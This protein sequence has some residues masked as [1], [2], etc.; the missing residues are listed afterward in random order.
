[1]AKFQAATIFINEFESRKLL[2][3]GPKLITF[4]H[5]EFP[6][7]VAKPPFDN[8]SLNGGSCDGFDT[9]DHF[10]SLTARCCSCLAVQ[11]ELGLWTK[12][13]HWID[14]G[15]RFDSAAVAGHLEQ[16]IRL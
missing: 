8:A 2:T 11:Q 12:R 1:L 6:A 7:T 5:P 16:W 13:W 9:P 15:D 10:D 14:P 3:A 4:I